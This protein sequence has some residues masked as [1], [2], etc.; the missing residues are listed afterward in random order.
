VF[1]RNL[2]ALDF[3][4]RYGCV[5]VRRT[6]GAENLEREPDVLLRWSPAL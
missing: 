6:D 3:Y 2:R 4:A 5:E 1:Q